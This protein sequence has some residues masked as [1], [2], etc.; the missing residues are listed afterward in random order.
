MMERLRALSPPWR[1]TLY[2]A[3]AL[4][5]FFLAAGVGAAAAVVAYWQAG[6]ATIGSAE[7]SS[8]ETSSAKAG[9]PEGTGEETTGTTRASEDT[10]ID[11]SGEAENANEKEGNKASFIH[12]ATDANSRGDY[13]VF[14]DPSI[15]EDP[16]AVVLVSLTSD[17]G[18][19]GD[20]SYE[21]NVG[22]WYAGTVRRWAIFNQDL[23][24]VPPGSAFEVIVPPDSAGFVHE[25][26]VLNTAGH[27]TY[28]DNRLTNGRPDAV[29][30]VTQN[31]NPG[32]GRGVYNDHTVGT[33]YDAK[34]E[35]WAIY[36]RDGA[37]MPEGAAFNVAVSAGEG[38]ATR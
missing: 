1:Y 30:D 4:T 36:N 34:L 14:S 26:G 5:L 24:P 10:A 13:T 21:H 29:L 8:F 25:A 23:A 6:E 2:L 38:E 27:Y 18:S 11:P 22:V 3:G 32:G 35:K 9:K 7:T 16:N 12:R 15:D 31:W 37:P 20:A 28:L 33:Q 19:S 17:R